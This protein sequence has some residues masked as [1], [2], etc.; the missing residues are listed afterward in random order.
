MKISACVLTAL[1]LFV[2]A[3]GEGR[4]QSP[5]QTSDWVKGG[6]RVPL[7]QAN[8]EQKAKFVANL[9]SKSASTAALGQ[10]GDSQ[11]AH[12]VAAA[13]KLV[14]QATADLAAGRLEVADEKLN[15][16]TDLV[17]DHTRRLTEET[18]KSNRAHQLYDS[19]L[20]STKALF[21]ALDRVMKEKGTTSE[22]AE[23]RAAAIQLL[24]DAG[25]LAAKGNYEAAVVQLD[26]AYTSVS[27][28]VAG[29]RNG[30]S[31]TNQLSFAS[32]GEEYVYEL[33]RND[34]HLL[35]LKMT[36]KEK[37]PES[38]LAAQAEARRAEAAELRKQAEEMA[39]A[40][41]Y[42]GAIKILGQSTDKLMQALRM[43]G[44][45]IPG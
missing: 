25:S 18:E 33:D 34:S 42:A 4:T 1:L 41:D 38:S 40:M 21:E 44:A 36:L 30:D 2:G 14:D 24:D 45:Y 12:A 26:K 11:A 23:K 5:G 28:Q 35:L 22:L 16:A 17:M 10:S 19:R 37:H 20:A 13:S 7:S 27:A 39:K 43:A 15:R 9:V 32:A 8:I 3:V 6:P 31:V 29:M